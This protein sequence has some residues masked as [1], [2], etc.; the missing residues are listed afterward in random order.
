MRR[1]PA[2][3]AGSPVITPGLLGWTVRLP[4]VPPPIEAWNW[5]ESSTHPIGTSPARWT[6]AFDLASCAKTRSW[7]WTCSPPLTRLGPAMKSTSQAAASSSNAPATTTMERVRAFMVSSPSK[8]P[9]S[10]L[11][12]LRHR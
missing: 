1:W 10:Y 4:L 12:K 9:L 11:N 3:T 7:Y 8:L 5:A 2:G 6:V